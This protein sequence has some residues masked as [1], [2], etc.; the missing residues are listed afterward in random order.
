MHNNFLQISRDI[1]NLFLPLEINNIKNFVL[2][3]IF[4]INNIKKMFRILKVAA[5]M[6][7]ENNLCF[8]KYTL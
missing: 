2:K 3:I 5:K 8:I 6:E 4:R 1:Y 7:M